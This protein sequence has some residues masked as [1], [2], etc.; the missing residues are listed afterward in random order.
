MKKVRIDHFGSAVRF[1]HLLDRLD[2]AI[3]GEEG[4]DLR[5]GEDAGFGSFHG[6]LYTA[7]TV[8]N[9]LH[10]LKFSVTI[11]FV[12]GHIICINN[13]IVCSFWIVRCKKEIDDE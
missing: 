9:L 8:S 12:S 7:K 4:G 13:H 1:H 3:H 6:A 5:V 10:L 11:L 2:G